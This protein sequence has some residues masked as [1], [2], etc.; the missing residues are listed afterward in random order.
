MINSDSS[1]AVDGLFAAGEV[2][3]GVHGKNRLMGNSLLDFNVFGRRAGITAAMHARK[4]QKPSKLTLDHL[5]KYNKE[6]KDAGIE[7]KN[8]SPM[9]LPEYRG[10]R[11]LERH[12]DVQ[13]TL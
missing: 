4:G 12:L 6:L 13:V 8:P 1:T 9:L 5:T 10:K 2:S 7:R 11:V 3:G